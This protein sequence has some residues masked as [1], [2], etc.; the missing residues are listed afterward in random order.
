MRVSRDMS[1]MQFQRELAKRGWEFDF[2]GYV[3]LDN[4]LRVYRFNA[5]D[6]LRTQLAYMIAENRKHT[7]KQRGKQS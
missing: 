5:G 4:G 3:R 2:G 1:T 7:I 6:R